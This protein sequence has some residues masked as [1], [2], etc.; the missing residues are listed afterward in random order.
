MKKIIQSEIDWQPVNPKKLLGEYI[1]TP[2]CQFWAQNSKY[3]LLQKFG[4]KFNIWN[5]A[6]PNGP[7]VMYLKIQNR[8]S[9]AS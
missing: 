4:N 6:P 2:L 8:L 3:P 1:F 5:I 7:V 9:R